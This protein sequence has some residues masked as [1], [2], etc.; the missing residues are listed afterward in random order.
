[1]IY[2]YNPW[3]RDM[4]F[5]SLVQIQSKSVC[6]QCGKHCVLDICLKPSSQ[7]FCSHLCGSFW[8]EERMEDIEWGEP[9]DEIDALAFGDEYDQFMYNEFVKEQD[10]QDY[11]YDSENE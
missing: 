1:M 5:S 2:E 4:M 6:K 11:E 3:P 8:L 10:I 9:E 7:I